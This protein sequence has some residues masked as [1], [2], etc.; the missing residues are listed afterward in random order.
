MPIVAFL[1]MSI[2]MKRYKI[3]IAKLPIRENKSHK[4]SDVIN[5]PSMNSFRKTIKG[6]IQTAAVMT[7]IKKPS[8]RE[9]KRRFNFKFLSLIAY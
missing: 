3:Q 8:I 9:A 5:L 4:K 2:G 6:A 1:K 7:N